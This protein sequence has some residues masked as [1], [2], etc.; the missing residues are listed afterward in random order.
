MFAITVFVTV[1]SVQ[2]DRKHHECTVVC[3]SGLCVWSVL[4]LTL[5]LSQSRHPVEHLNV[6]VNVNVNVNFTLEHATKCQRESRC[7]A[8][9]FI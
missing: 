9:L 4:L 3:K 6:Y 2:T 1:L 7:I 5:F 8:L